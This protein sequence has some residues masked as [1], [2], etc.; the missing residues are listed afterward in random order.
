MAE[1]SLVLLRFFPMVPNL[2][3]RTT[4]TDPA[5]HLAPSDLHIQVL[6]LVQSQLPGINSLTSILS[7]P[8][9]PGWAVY[10]WALTFPLKDGQVGK[11]E[12]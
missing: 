3:L 6:F 7:A 1:H 2:G 9:S 11:E 10:F 4:P 5:P 12:Q 8:V